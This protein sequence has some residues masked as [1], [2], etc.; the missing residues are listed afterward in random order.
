MSVVDL[1][2]MKIQHF[3]K[4]LKRSRA[5]TSKLLRF[6]VLKMENKTKIPRNQDGHLLA[7]C[8]VNKGVTIGSF[9]CT[10]NC[11]HNKNTRKEI[12]SQAFDLEFVR[13]E[14]IIS[15]NQ[16]QIEL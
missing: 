9:D 8:K 14:A 1:L 7:N 11:E 13:C 10:A 3:K 2:Q 5:T 15:S 12:E 4:N 16:L 6:C